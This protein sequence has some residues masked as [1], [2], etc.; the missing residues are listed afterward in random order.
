[1]LDGNFDGFHGINVKQKRKEAMMVS[2]NQ[3]SGWLYFPKTSLKNVIK[4]RHDG[5]SSG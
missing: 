3:Q 1:L 4:L 2:K 5:F